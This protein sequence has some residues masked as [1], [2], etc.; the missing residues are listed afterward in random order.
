LQKVQLSRAIRRSSRASF[1]Q[2]RPCRVLERSLEVFA[3][4]FVELRERKLYRG[5]K[6]IVISRPKPFQK[7]AFLVVD[8]TPTASH[9]RVEHVCLDRA[10]RLPA[11]SRGC[12][13]K[14]SG[15]RLVAGS[16]GHFGV[17]Q[18]VAR[19]VATMH[20]VEMTHELGAR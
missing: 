7:C 18:M 10:R 14:G 6:L 13:G 2:H 16:L 5:A 12:I 3:P 15:A 8:V 9:A 17:C 4:M 11:S 1:G 20:I 19:V